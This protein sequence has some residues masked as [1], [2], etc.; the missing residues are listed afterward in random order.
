METPVFGAVHIEV[1]DGEALGHFF[2]GGLVVQG[3]FGDNN[4][5]GMDGEVVGEVD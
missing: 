2:E 5:S 3:L 1:G 4:A